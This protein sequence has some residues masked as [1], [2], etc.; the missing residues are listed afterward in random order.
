MHVDMCKITR[1]HTIMRGILN[2]KFIL[3]T[4]VSACGAVIAFGNPVSESVAETLVNNRDYMAQNTATGKF[5]FA[6]E[7]LDDEELTKEDLEELSKYEKNLENRE[8][9]MGGEFEELKKAEGYESVLDGKED[10][11][12][13]LSILEEVQKSVNEAK[14]FHNMKQMLPDFKKTF[15][16]LKDAREYHDKTV[17]YL[18]ESSECAVGYLKTHYENPSSVWFGKNCGFFGPGT[19]YCH[20]QPE[21]KFGD[22]TESKGLYDDACL[23]DENHLCYI[24]KLEENEYDLGVAG[25]LLGYYN[26]GKDAD[27]MQETQAYLREGEQEPEVTAENTSDNEYAAHVEISGEPAENNVDKSVYVVGR[28][29]TALVDKDNANSSE[30]VPNISSVKNTKKLD[31]KQA[32]ENTKDSKK[33]EA[34]AEESRKGHLMNWIWGSQVA[35]DISR[36]LDSEQAQFG[37]R[38]KRFRLWND[39]KEFYDQYIDGKYDNI[40][41]YVQKAPMPNALITAATEINNIFDYKPIS[42]KDA[43]G[44]EKLKIEPETV[45]EEIA[46]AISSIDE[47]EFAQEDKTKEAI[48]KIIADEEKYLA[49]LKASH[50]KKLEQLTAQKEQLQDALDKVNSDLSDTNESIN[51]D[52]ETVAS[53]VNTDREVQE[54]DKYSKKV[55]SLYSTPIDIDDSPINKKFTEEK[56]NSIEAETAAKSARTQKLSSIAAKE[57]N[58]KF[59][60]AELKKVKEKIEDERREFVKEYS[61]AEEKLR[62]EFVEKVEELDVKVIEDSTVV[63]KITEAISKISETLSSQ[64]NL[65]VT[66]PLD[67]ADMAGKMISCLRSEAA[68]IANNT[69]DE[70]TS[71]RAGESIY[72]PEKAEYINGIHRSMITK[73]KQISSCSVDGLGSEVIA[74][75]VFGK[76]CDDINCLVPSTDKDK[77]GLTQYFVGELPVKDD[78]KAPTSPVEFS[79]A[80]VREVFHLDLIDYD[81]IEKYYENEENLENNADITVTADGFLNS[82]L[83]MPL[84]WKYILRRH[85][86]GHKQFELTRLLGNSEFGDEVRGDPD[87]SF[88]RSGSFP[89]YIDNN[90]VD[91][92]PLMKLS[93]KG[94][95]WKL[96]VENFGYTINMTP[97]TH[98]YDKVLCKGLS[99]KDNKVIDYAVDSG[100]PG[101]IPEASV[102]GLITDTSELGTI[103]AYVPNVDTD[104]LLSRLLNKK[105]EKKE[106]SRKLTF[107][108]SL[109]K[110]VSIIS[111]SEDSNDD[112]E[113]EA[114]FYLATRSL[115]DR[116]QFGDFLNQ[117]EQETL[118]RESL[119]KAENQIEEILKN[120]QDMFY[121]T[122]IVISEDFDLLNDDDY[123]QAADALDEQKQIYINKAKKDIAQVK[124]F[125]ETVKNRSA[126]LLHSIAVLE[127]DSNELTQ[128]NGDEELNELVEKIKNRVADNAVMDTY[129]AEN[130]EA[131]ERRIRQLQ[132]PYCEVHPSK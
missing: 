89:C 105:T 75:K 6:A 1:E 46:K 19:I 111:K 81:N 43:L 131:Q 4:I 24:M 12:A 53:S 30:I 27:A 72:Y 22:K 60:S 41:Q 106:V 69:K 14:N 66:L 108:A 125:T 52:S 38:I 16:E 36:D 90:V 112:K 78:L 80:P 118:A 126:D 95:V 93:K 124:G 117:M 62:K 114:L 56:N 59:L 45:R 94:L 83:E 55:A 84:I 103:L 54:N 74:D 28:D 3:L 20:Y 113:K 42:L 97:D 63:A 64:Y 101:N 70:L 88:I 65:P 5:V 44:N 76:M 23:D 110:A 7:L 73:M 47:Q 26:Q 121:G 51:K 86:Y 99:I 57:K 48:D 37:T 10:D 34:L 107:N 122:S 100:T 127:A 49:E 18:Q 11:L 8:N 120:L 61:D 82:G 85:T 119:M 104:N 40:A 13:S 128:I 50:E 79:S 96:S 29:D 129:E 67:A 92:S 77:Q 98:L 132:P 102:K 31:D 35:T 71:L 116:N 33:A 17:E 32:D 21:K 130:A 58:S 115:F 25:L 87:K 39:Q 109:Q 91:I 123:K 68:L 9:I 2:L 15:Q